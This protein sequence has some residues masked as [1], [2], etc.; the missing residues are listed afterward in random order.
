MSHGDRLIRAQEEERLRKEMLEAREACQRAQEAREMSAQ[1]SH[2]FDA[3]NPDGTYAL[4]KAEAQHRDALDRYI[5]ALRNLSD[6]LL[7][8]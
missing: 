4:A 3:S 8:R 7:K 5:T 1:M 2:A 6:F